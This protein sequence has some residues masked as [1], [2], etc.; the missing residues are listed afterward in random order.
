MS[1]F[2]PLCPPPP[3]TSHSLGQSLHLCSCLWVMCISSLAT[4]FPILY[5]TF[6]WLF[7]NYQFIL[8]NPLTSN[9]FPKTPSHL[10]MTHTWAYSDSHHLSSST[11]V[12]A[13]RAP[14]AYGDE[15][16]CLASGQELGIAFYWTEWQAE[17]ILLFLNIPPI[18]P[19]TWQAG[20][21]S[22]TPSTWLTHLPHLGV[23]LRLIP[24]C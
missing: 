2:F 12:T 23:F 11:R 10:A 17:A 6:P 20:V 15:L 14:V 19:H 1:H 4:P 7:C 8:L 9:P 3:S 5:F 18:K 13:R 22:E 24:N 16:K 21:I